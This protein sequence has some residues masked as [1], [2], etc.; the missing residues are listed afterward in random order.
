[1]CKP[2][3]A[4]CWVSCMP[5]LVVAVTG[6][7]GGGL[8]TQAV[9]A[10][11]IVAVNAAATSGDIRD[12]AFDRYVDYGLLLQAYS[13]MNAE[14][15][16]DVG[17]QLAEGERVLLRHHKTFPADA[18]LGLAVKA[19]VEK[20]DKAALDRLAK[21]AEKSNSAALKSQVAAAQKLGG[22]SRAVNTALLVSLDEMTPEQ[23]LV[24][25][26]LV[27]GL[28]RARFTGDRAAAESLA[29]VVKQAD[30]PEAKRNSLAKLVDECLAAVPKERAADP[31]TSA[32]DK[33]LAQT[34]RTPQPRNTT[35]IGGQ[36]WQGH[37]FVSH[38]VHSNPQRMRPVTSTHSNPVY[39]RN[40]AYNPT[41][42]YNQPAV[43]S[44]VV[45]GQGQGVASSP[46]TSS[47]LTITINGSFQGN[48]TVGQPSGNF[49]TDN[50]G[51]LVASQS[52][53][54]DP[55]GVGPSGNVQTDP[56]SS[57]AVADPGNGAPDPGSGVADPSSGAP[58]NNSQMTGVDN[59]DNQNGGTPDA[60]SGGQTDQ[61]DPGDGSGQGTDQG[62]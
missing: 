28:Q 25:R 30:L 19:A 1:M 40:P 44:G 20:K 24:Y 18:I 16:T 8:A 61:T 46:G 22:Q 11:V 59:G 14:M 31:I 51:Q 53:T 26:E 58:D 55:S 52:G 37:R 6:L 39:N 41:P 54:G 4:M 15:L 32:L 33:L 5:V 43:T 27:R 2:W 42:V 50:G 36:P 35:R 21:A 38:P 3:S 12:P 17:L 57:V 47:P 56:G 62:Q 7:F 29:Q 13:T 49:P 10:E 23:F 9:A 45:Y 34:R 48:N 60:G